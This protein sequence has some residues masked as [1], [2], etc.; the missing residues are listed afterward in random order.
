MV[1]HFDVCPL[2]LL[3]ATKDSDPLCMGPFALWRH[4]SF[5]SHPVFVYPNMLYSIRETVL[6]LVSCLA[7]YYIHR[8]LTFKTARNMEHWNG[9]LYI[10]ADASGNIGG[11]IW[12]WWWEGTWKV[13][14]IILINNLNS[15]QKKMC[16]KYWYL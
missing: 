7:A 2:L 13:I 15:I 8:Q 6:N 3:W 11:H 14:K 9:T 12:S 1:I 5:S 10:R 16:S 4:L